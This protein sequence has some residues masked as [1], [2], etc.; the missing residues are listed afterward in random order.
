MHPTAYFDPAIPVGRV[1]P[2]YRA[3]FTS[4]CRSAS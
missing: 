2:S 3:G 4:Q 1:A